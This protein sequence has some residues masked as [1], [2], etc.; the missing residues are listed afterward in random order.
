MNARIK[1]L[2]V[3]QGLYGY[4]I[5]VFQIRNKITPLHEKRAFTPGVLH[6]NGWNV[7]ELVRKRVTYRTA[8]R[9]TMKAGDCGCWW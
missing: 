8:Y 5:V 4:D 6:G 9:F 3:S 2:V 1:S 7:S